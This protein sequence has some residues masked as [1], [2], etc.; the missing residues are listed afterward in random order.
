MRKKL[1]IKELINYS[2]ALSVA[3]TL[4]FF[5][6]IYL[7]DFDLMWGLYRSILAGAL[8]LAT[9]IINIGLIIIWAKKNLRD[10]A[11][12]TGLRFLFGCSVNA[13]ILLLFQFL[14][15][16]TES[17]ELLSSDYFDLREINEIHGW[18][19]YILILIS[20]VMVYSL[21]YLL[22]N[23]ILLQ[24]I[25]TQTE[26]EVSLLRSANAETT[27]Q[28]LKRQIHPHFL[29]N[30]LNVLKSLIKMDP[31]AAE[32]YLINLSDFLRSSLNQ[33]KKGTA[34]VQEEIKL[35]KDYLEMQQI[36]FGNALKYNF[37]IPENYLDKTLPFFSL[38]PLAEN[39]IKHNILTEEHPLSIQ[40]GVDYDLIQ[41]KNNLQRK[42]SVETST[43]NGL[44]NLME[45]YR[46]LSGQQIIIRET[47]DSFIV[48][49]KAL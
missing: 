3:I 17:H 24:H 16:W 2:I 42:P 37:D 39:A 11:P 18:Q 5:I 25:K 36:R 48:A 32:R 8:L 31:A 35:C 46:L 13:G 30:A 28:L 15:N 14:R 33:N 22:H 45:R 6:M 29:F 38:Q 10:S 43:G 26:L 7:Q 27:N 34:T 19:L 4:F 47:N 21:V 9:C 1:P 23:F 41:V 20:S 12:N 49:F 40:I 44:A